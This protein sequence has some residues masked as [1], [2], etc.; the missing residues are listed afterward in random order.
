M[1]NNSNA[2]TQINGKNICDLHTHSLYSDGTYTPA[3]LIE[4]AERIGLGAIALCDHNTTAGLSE[5]I[6]AAEGKNVE[7]ITGIEFSTEYH[8]IELHMLALFINEEH[9]EMIE[10]L[11]S[12]MRE[13]KEARNRELIEALLAD[14]YRIDYDKIKA[15]SR[16]QINRAH[17]AEALVNGG[18]VSS[19]KEAFSMF[20]APERGYY[21]PPE[22]LPVFEVID[23]IG[24]IGAISVLAHPFLSLDEGK[25]REFLREAK[26]HGLVGMETVY[27]KYDEETTLLSKK[28][29]KEFGLLESGGSD[30]HGSRK[31]D[32]ALGV[33]R[34]ELKVEI[35]LLEKLKRA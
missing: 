17:I 9:F 28:I 24:E 14:G 32:I 4:E 8:N 16:G 3:E 19:I 20:L 34:G 33:G 27:S 23:F 5:F 11:V 31:P 30:F 7:A 10:A 18:Y 2:T 15:E 13:R 12:K 22:R 6:R 26:E 21:K 25:L 29:A 35:E 1:S